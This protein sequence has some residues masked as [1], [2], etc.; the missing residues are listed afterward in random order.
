MLNLTWKDLKIITKFE[1]HA[2]IAEQLA[3]DLVIYWYLQM[4]IK[5]TLAHSNQPCFK[6]CYLSY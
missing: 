5:T 1:S 2:G 4:N 3:M 6:F